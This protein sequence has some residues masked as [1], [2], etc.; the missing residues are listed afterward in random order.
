MA[1]KEKGLRER[2]TKELNSRM[3][4][5]SIEEI[6]NEVLAEITEIKLEMYLKTDREELFWEQ[7]V[8]VNWLQ[9]E[10]RNTKFFHRW[11]SYRRKKNIIK[12]L[13]NASGR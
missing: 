8:R 9:M 7:R 10:D 4:E 6:N 1:K 12:G 3:L 11:A 5:F 2:R 13:E